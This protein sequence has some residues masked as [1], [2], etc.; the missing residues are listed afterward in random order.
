MKRMFFLSLLVSTQFALAQD[1]RVKIEDFSFNYTD[2]K[3]SGEA[4]LFEHNQKM[5]EGVQVQVEKIGDAMN[6][7]VTGSEE[8]E[9]KLEHAPDVVMK[10]RTMN[11][12]DLDLSYQDN[13][14]FSVLEGEFIG[15][16]DELHLKNFALN[17]LKDASQTAAE[18]QLI[19]GCLKKMSVKSQ[20]FSQAAV[21]E[22]MVSA[23]TKALQNVAGSRGD[24]AIKGLDFRVNDGKYNLDADVNAQMSGHAQSKGN[25]SY[26]PSSGIMTIKISEVKFGILNV[27]G[28]VF[29]QLK[30]NENA[31]MKVKQPNVYYKLK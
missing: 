3:G 27:T 8:H 7:K 17:C 10:A 16:D 26:D 21:E 23:F 13:L 6:F 11:V 19:F 20:S 1:V 25:L 5:A 2:P 29:D 4:S 24:L 28:M 12:D 22:G 30:K 9:F 15:A 18:N 14:S 31:R